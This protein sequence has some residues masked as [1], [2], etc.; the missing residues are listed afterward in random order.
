MRIAGTTTDRLL[1]GMLEDTLAGAQCP[2]E[3]DPRELSRDGIAIGWTGVGEP[4]AH[5]DGDLACVIDGTVFNAPGNDAEHVCRLHREHG[6]R[7]ALERLNADFAIALHDRRDGTLWVARDRFGVRPLYYLRDARRFAFASRPRSL[8]RLP[9]VSRRL[10]RR[11]AGLFAAS[12]YRTFDNDRD[13]SPYV[14]VAQLPAGQLLRLQDGRLHKEPWWTLEEASD[15]DAPPDELAERYRE[16]LLD[17]VRL[18]LGRASSPAFTLSGGM[19]S[20]SVIA[21]AVELTGERQTAF[22]TLYSGSEYDE[23][24]EIRSM[25]DKAV[26]QWQQVRVD[27]PDVAGLVARMIEAHDEP[28]ATATWLSHYVLCGEV[29]AGGFGTLFGGLGGDELNAGEYEYFIFRFAD[30]RQNGESDA[31]GHE[32]EAWVRHHDHPIFRKSWDAMEAGFGRLVDFDRPG[33]ILADRGRMERYRAALEPAV[34]DFGS[35]EPVMDRPFHSYLKNR[36][37]QDVFRETAP[38]C[39]RAEDR[40]TAAYGLRNCDPFFDHRLVE[41]MFRVPGSL[42]IEDGVTKRLLRRAM[43]GILPEETRTRVKKTGW[44]A[45]A[46]AW[47]AG[48]GR[49]LLHD[50]VGSQD[51]R[52]RD[53]YAVGE[54]RRLIDEHDEIVSSGEP[55]EN[56]MMFLWQL[57]NVELWLRWLDDLG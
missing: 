7:G 29:A 28:V 25:L 37:Y 51:F 6:F 42:K 8:L 14:D 47:F 10:D 44:N 4:S 45:P 12:H 23:S 11:Y 35:W 21:C 9:G 33:R 54:V 38:C 40:Q 15:H 2:L 5:D 34:F 55:R 31:L 43:T 17:A 27:A 24:E 53:I 32:V 16:L 30:M 3:P 48:G 39:L 13:A 56:H 20:S 18:R 26:E 41:L 1:R 49:E 57:L 52:A 22:S 50:L 46:D 36:T 19:D